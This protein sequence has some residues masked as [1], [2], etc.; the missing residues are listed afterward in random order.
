M[1]IENLSHLV[2]LRVLNLAGNEITVANNLSG[3]ESLTELNLRRNKIGSVVS[4]ITHYAISIDF[5]FIASAM[6]HKN[7]KLFLDMNPKD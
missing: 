7:L 2:E 6:I 4:L 1:K 5:F 3:L